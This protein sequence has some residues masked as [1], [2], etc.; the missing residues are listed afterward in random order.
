MS[1]CRAFI[2]CNSSQWNTT[3]TSSSYCPS[4]C[5]YLSFL[6]DGF[7]SLI[8][9]STMNIVH[10]ELPFGL[11]HDTTCTQES[12]QRPEG[13]QDHP[14]IFDVNWIIA[15]LQLCKRIAL[16]V[17]GHREKLSIYQVS[18]YISSQCIIWS[19]KSVLNGTT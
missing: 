12:H 2:A 19:G 15:N 9:S 4:I 5:N 13:L 18:T 3:S 6:A 8:T 14:K 11:P 7:T 1:H 17:N 10:N 16:A